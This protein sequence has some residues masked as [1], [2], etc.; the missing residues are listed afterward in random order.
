M[1]DKSHLFYKSGE[2]KDLNN[3]RGIT[4]NSCLG[5]FFTLLLNSRLTNFLDSNNIIKPNQIGFRNSLSTAHRIFV[6]KT[7]IDSYSKDNKKL[8]VCFLDF[9]KAY[10]CLEEWPCFKLINC[11]TRKRLLKFYVSCTAMLGPMLKLTMGCLIF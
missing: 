11:G 2:T 6:L 9:K 1:I 10:D 7:I 8:F 5:K 4:I 3:Y